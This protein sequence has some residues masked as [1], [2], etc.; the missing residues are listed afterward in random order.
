MPGLFSPGPT[1]A[2]VQITNQW[3]MTIPANTT[4][5]VRIGKRTYTTKWAQPLGQGQSFGV[6][7]GV[8]GSSCDATVP[9]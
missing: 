7:F 2:L 5:S 4:Y 3:A 6:N 8:A 1:L 9:G